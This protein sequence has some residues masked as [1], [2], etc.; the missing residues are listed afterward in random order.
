[1][2]SR[3]R[4]NHCGRYR[5]RISDL[6]GGGR[7]RLVPAGSSLGVSFTLECPWRRPTRLATLA[8]Q[9][10][11]PLCPQAIRSPSFA[12]PFAPPRSPLPVRLSLAVRLSQVDSL[13]FASPPVAAPPASFASP[14]LIARQRTS[15]IGT[16]CGERD[17]RMIA[18]KHLIPRWRWSGF[19]TLAVRTDGVTARRRRTSTWE[20]R[21]AGR[22]AGRPG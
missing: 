5:C 8:S 18:P 14:R 12:S 20:R 17:A 16:D 7:G 9:P 19:R 15:L 11:T 2:E 4:A 10:P 13:P 3:T 6:G 22:P 1:V 21:Q